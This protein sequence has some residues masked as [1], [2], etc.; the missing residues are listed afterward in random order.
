MAAAVAFI[1]VTIPSHN[2]APLGEVA[3]NRTRSICWSQAITSTSNEIQVATVSQVLKLLTNLRL[4][5]LI[6]RIQATQ[7]RLEC[8]DI[9]NV[10]FMSANRFNAFH[11]FDQPAS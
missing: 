3:S 8:V 11:H 7:V 2:L 1:I 10:E 4:D 9:I 5:V 6:A